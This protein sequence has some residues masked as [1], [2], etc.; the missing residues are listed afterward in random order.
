M[1]IEIDERVAKSLQKL[2]EQ[3]DQ[4]QLALHQYLDLLAE[5]APLEPTTKK[6]QQEEFDA[7]PG[8]DR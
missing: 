5:S 6:S 3:A 4:R 1:T 2:K 8:R 7:D